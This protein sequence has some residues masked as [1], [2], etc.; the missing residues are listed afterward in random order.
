MKLF[1]VKLFRLTIV[2][3]VLVILMAIGFVRLRIETDVVSSLPDKDPVVAGAMDVFKN[4]PIQDRLF[5]DVAL[6]GGEPD[7]LIRLGDTVEKELLQSGLFVTVGMDDFKTIFPDLIDYTITG[8]PLLFTAAELERDVRPRLKPEAIHNQLKEIYAQLSGMEG[9]GQ[10]DIISRDPLGLKNLVLA[11]MASLVPSAGVRFYKGKLLSQDS[12]HLLVSAVPKASGTDTAPARAIAA[13]ME[14]VQNRLDRQYS[15]AFPIITPM[16][17]YRAALDNETIIRRDV[18][19]AITLATCGIALLLLIAFPRPLIGLMSL[20]PAIAGATMA[21]FVYSLWHDTVSIMV[22]GFGGAVISISVDHGIAYL[23][24]ADRPHQT[25]GREA[26]REV[27]AIGLVAVL[28]TMGAF[29]ALSFSGFPIFEQLG[30][31]TALGIGF[32]FLFVHTVFPL[33]MPELPPAGRKGLVLQPVADRL[34]FAGKTGLGVAIMFVAVMGYFARPE[35]SVSLADMNT[36]SQGTRAAERLMT[37]VWGDFLGNRKIFM[38]VSGDSIDD[39]QHKGDRLLEQFETEIDA[40]VL[41]AAFVPSAILPGR[42]RAR[43][44]AAAWRQ[45]WARERAAGFEEVLSTAAGGR[46]FSADAFEPFL[47]LTRGRADQRAETIPQDWLSFFSISAPGNGQGW[48]QF[49]T[50]T[51]GDA[52]DP[53]QFFED[54]GS[55]GSIFDPTYFSVRLGGLL[56][57]SFRLLFVGVGAMAAILLFFLFVDLSLTLIALLPV[58]FALVCTLGTLRLSGHPIDIPGLMLAIVIFGMG[59]DYSIF[60]V[61]S[62]QRY[63]TMDHP[64]FGLIRM[65]VLMASASTLIGFGALCMAE[66]SILKSAGFISVLGIGYSLIGA[67]VILPPVLAFRFRERAVPVSGDLHTQV[68]HRYRNME[69]YPRMFA[70]FKLMTDPMFKELRDFF[71]GDE[72]FRVILDI[73]SGYGVPANWCLSRFPQ[74][75]VFGIDPDGERIRVATQAVGSRGH[76]AVGA[77]PDIPDAPEPA[78]CAFMLDMIH[79]ITDA[80][81]RLVLDRLNAKLKPGGKLVLRAVIQPS[82]PLPWLWWLETVRLKLAGIAAYHRPPETVETMLREAGFTIT[83]SQSSGSGGDLHWIISDKGTTRRA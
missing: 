49:L 47:S 66:H 15:G 56:S 9:I 11:R 20:L 39:L 65:A 63:R 21:F 2:L 22:L 7:D 32:S 51:T 82:T 38:V 36:V 42:E 48:R 40:G 35:F 46:G 53:R 50:L 13:L 78:D 75:Q 83:R 34:A 6:P 18:E 8:L 61:R 31:F 80:Q 62:Y 77:A 23:L 33:V 14:D 72:V 64:F 4:N 44:N 24:F 16:G 57:D 71:S 37:R 41:T 10:A 26:A 29:G 81:L 55:T 28:T 27:W 59:I 60:F 17:A 3:L 74:A 54:Y 68:R 73:G 5:I 79:Y 52:Y 76:M 69:A 43:Q 25:R 1:P 12:T 19:R 30:Q 45:F 70:R 67:F 58:V